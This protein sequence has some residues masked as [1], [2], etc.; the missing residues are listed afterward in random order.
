MTTAS[1]AHRASAAGCLVIA[2]DG[3]VLGFVRADEGRTGVALPCGGLEEGESFEDAA[4]REVMEET[5][6][7]VNLVKGI[8]PFHEVEQRDDVE[9]K[10]FLAKII[11]KTEA[12]HL[13]EGHYSWVNP[14][15]VFTGPYGSFN[16]RM[17]L[18]LSNQ[19]GNLTDRDLAKNSYNYSLE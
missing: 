19:F 8:L 4:I 6:F 10:F 9:V 18:F 2:I 1:S 17:F 15:D 5:G 13:H 3:K 12:T 11:G 16:E 7:I 14:I